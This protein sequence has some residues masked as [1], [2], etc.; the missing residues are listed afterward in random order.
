MFRETWIS[1]FWTAIGPID[2]YDF[3][4][5]DFLLFSCCFWMIFMFPG[6]LVRCFFYYRWGFIV[7]VG[8]HESTSW[9]HDFGSSPRTKIMK[10]HRFRFSHNHWRI[11]RFWWFW[12]SLLQMQY[13]FSLENH[14]KCAKSTQARIAEASWARTSCLAFCRRP[15]FLHWSLKILFFAQPRNHCGH[16]VFRATASKTLIFH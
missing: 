14:Y 3:Q 12:R 1:A 13:R 16:C 10:F 6:A 7:K 9:R 8:S 15:Y 5:C 11:L 4:V 2:F